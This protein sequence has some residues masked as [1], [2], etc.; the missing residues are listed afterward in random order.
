M[1]AAIIGCVIQAGVAAA[2]ILNNLRYKR[3]RSDKAAR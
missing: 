2:C 1:T 3:S